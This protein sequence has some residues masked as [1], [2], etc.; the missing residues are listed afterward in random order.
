MSKEWFKDWFDENYKLLYRHRD[1]KDAENQVELILRVVRPDRDWRILDL[2]CGEGRH[3][4][5]FKD[6]GFD[7]T[8]IDLSKTLIDIGREKFPGLKLIECDMRNIP[9]SYDMIL[10]LFT[11]FGYFEEEK[12]DVKV[13]SEVYN[14]L[15]SGGVFWFDFLNENYVRKNLNDRK[16][17]KTIDDIKITEEKS[18]VDN[19][20][21]KRIFFLS[22]AGSR[23][24]TESVRLYSKEELTM[25]L[26]E[27]GFNIINVFGDYLGND[28]NSGSER[29]IFYCNK[30]G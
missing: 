21:N 17:E 1:M 24:Y 30:T 6:R 26:D 13:L 8:G 11:S 28:W 14:S 19:R 12:E 25:M 18:I 22:S 16:T 20:V 3:S 10:S 27:T 7:I 23:E 29:S 2:A 9:G 15:N 4:T 5:F